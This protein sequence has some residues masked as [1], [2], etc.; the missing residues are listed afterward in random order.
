MPGSVPVTG[1]VRRPHRSTAGVWGDGFSSDGAIALG[2]VRDL[3]SL[4]VDELAVLH[5]ALASRGSPCLAPLL[6]CRLATAV[7]VREGR[8][9]FLR[10]QGVL[11]PNH[12]DWFAHGRRTLAACR[13][14]GI[15]P[16][17]PAAA[18]REGALVDALHALSS[19]ASRGS[20]PPWSASAEAV[21]GFGSGIHPGYAWP[22]SAVTHGRG[23]SAAWLGI[24][25]R[26]R[27][28]YMP[29]AVAEFMAD[30]AVFRDKDLVSLVGMPA[31]ARMNSAA[32]R[33][34]DGEDG[35]CGLP[36]VLRLT[37]KLAAAAV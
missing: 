9:A 25:A 37:E 23:Y 16:A 22:E 13:A 14:A 7:A 21:L 28:A 15:G 19:C 30:D 8:L 32:A 27:R 17:H 5:P 29:P 35:V 34:L 36:S 33:R 20:L 6:V 26:G 2:R 3:A 18:S 4:D 31:L 10:G 11:H 12:A 1:P 24:V